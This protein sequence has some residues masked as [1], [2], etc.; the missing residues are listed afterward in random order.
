M[1]K[2][3]R[4]DREPDDVPYTNT[5]PEEPGDNAEWLYALYSSQY[6]QVWGDERTHNLTKGPPGE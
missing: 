6:R 4:S 3:F 5:A 2:C 1:E